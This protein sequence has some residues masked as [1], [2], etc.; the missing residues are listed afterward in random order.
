M[1]S[2]DILFLLI[3]TSNNYFI[4]AINIVLLMDMNEQIYLTRNILVTRLPSE[5][6]FPVKKI[7]IIVSQRDN[8]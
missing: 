7:I 4:V 2:K 3:N 8:K 6:L 5:M 1:T